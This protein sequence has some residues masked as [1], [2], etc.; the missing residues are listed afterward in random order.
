MA[1][2]RRIAIGTVACVLV[3]GAVV[4]PLGGFGSGADSRARSSSIPADR[5]AGGK[6]W[7]NPAAGPVPAIEPAKMIGGQS[8]P[9]PGS[10]LWPD[11]GSWRAG[12]H[13]HATVV[14]A[15]GDPRHQSDGLFSI[16]REN[17]LK[18]SQTGKLVRVPGTGPVTITKAP[19]GR[20]VVVSA[21]K[22][23][24]IEFTSKSGIRGTLH[25]KDDTVTLN[26]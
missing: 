1:R 9:V 3:A 12:S 10:V 23:G 2:K 7:D 22:H 5:G 19:L 4:V 17:S 14:T 21:Q 8:G 26:P 16:L 6:H 25:L 20:K 13:T 18:A 24:N 11:T 15:G